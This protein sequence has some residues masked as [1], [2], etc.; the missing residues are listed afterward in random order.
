MP[1]RTC[2]GCQKTEAQQMLVRWVAESTGRI[3]L[4]ERKRQPGRGAYTHRSRACLERAVGGGFSRSFRR[5]MQ[6][7]DVKRLWEL[8]LV[9]DEESKA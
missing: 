6:P 8:V 4:D 5:R 9:E 2:V 7:L 1:T 3:K